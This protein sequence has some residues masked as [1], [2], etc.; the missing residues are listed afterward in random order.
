MTNF[1]SSSTEDPQLIIVMQ[2]HILMKAFQTDGL[3][4]RASR[5]TL[6]IPRTVFLVEIP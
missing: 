4:L 2:T 6:F 3:D 1:I 5:D